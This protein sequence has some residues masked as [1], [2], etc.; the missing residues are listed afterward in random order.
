MFDI[1]GVQNGIKYGKWYTLVTLSVKSV[2]GK[3]FSLPY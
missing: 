1:A 2:T 3:I